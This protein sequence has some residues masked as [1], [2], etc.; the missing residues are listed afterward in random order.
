MV[1]IQF[2]VEIAITVQNKFLIFI[3]QSMFQVRVT[4]N[5]CMYI[6]SC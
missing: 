6:L 4:I 1:C 2:Y 3:V 5:E